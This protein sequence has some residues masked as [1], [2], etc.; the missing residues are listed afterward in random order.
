MASHTGHLVATSNAVL[1]LSGSVIFVYAVGSA[2]ALISVIRMTSETESPYLFPESGRD[3]PRV[4]RGIGSFEG[5][6]IY[7]DP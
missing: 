5:I 6:K 7:K 2:T 1:V 3:Q 4:V